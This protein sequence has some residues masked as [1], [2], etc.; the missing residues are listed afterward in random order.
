MTPGFHA[1]LARIERKPRRSAITGVA[2]EVDRHG[3]ITAHPRAP[4]WG[5]PLRVL[6]LLGLGGLAFKAVLF[7]LLGEEAYTSR[8]LRLGEGE[9]VE[10]ASAWVM[11][12]DPVTVA[13]AGILDDL[14][15]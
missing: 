8:V 6:A 13:V 1:F 3:L 5:A 11:Q 9:L 4:G 7:A 2:Y 15:R 12:A 14:G 10:R